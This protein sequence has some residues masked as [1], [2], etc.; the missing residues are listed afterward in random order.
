MSMRDIFNTSGR[1]IR[2]R[3]D[4]N[5]DF[6]LSFMILEAGRVPDPEHSWPAFLYRC[7]GKITRFVSLLLNCHSEA[8]VTVPAW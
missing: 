1:N 8:I 7:I 2:T 6:N 5:S 4:M 3:H